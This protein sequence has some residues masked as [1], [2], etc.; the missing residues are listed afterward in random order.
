MYLCGC[1]TTSKT[2]LAKGS[3]VT[4]DTRQITEHSPSIKLNLLICRIIVLNYSSTLI[5]MQRILPSITEK[6]QACFLSLSPPDPS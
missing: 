4:L 3:A 6:T 5:S 1:R 2:C